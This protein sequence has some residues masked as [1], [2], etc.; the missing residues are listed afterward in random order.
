MNKETLRF[1]KGKLVYL[2]GWESEPFG[3]ALNE[4][5]ALMITVRELRRGLSAISL[6]GEDDVAMSKMAASEQA[7]KFVVSFRAA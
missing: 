7:D 1:G 5:G 4:R 3:R 6:P 2:E